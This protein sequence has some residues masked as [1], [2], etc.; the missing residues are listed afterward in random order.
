MKFIGCENVVNIREHAKAE[1]KSQANVNAYQDHQDHQVVRVMTQHFFS[2]L[3]IISAN[4]FT[5]VQII[6][7]IPVCYALPHRYDACTTICE[8]AQ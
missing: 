5:I 7:F 1:I 8:L 2:H 4:D 3:P 6:K